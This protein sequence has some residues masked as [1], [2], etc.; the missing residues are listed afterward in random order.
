MAEIGADAL[1]ATR[2]QSHPENCRSNLRFNSF[3]A[4]SYALLY[5]AT[6][7]AACTSLKWWFSEL[8]GCAEKV[9]ASE[10]SNESSPEL[11]IHDQ[12]WR[13][14]PNCT[15]L[16][17]E[18]ILARFE[19]PNL[20]RFCLVRN[21]FTRTFSAWQSK[22]LLREPLQVGPYL[23]AGFYNIPVHSENDI[24]NAFE[25]FLEYLHAQ[26]FPQIRDAHV[27]SQFSI[28]RPDLLNFSMVAK[29]EEPEQLKEKLRGHLKDAY[30]D[31][32]S[33]SR[34]NESLIPYH[35]NFLTG[36][37]CELIQLMYSDD[38]DYFQYTRT[39]PDGKR[40]L[41]RDDLQVA[42][43]SV[44]MIRG[45]HQRIS[46]MR[47]EF[48]S[49]RERAQREIQELRDELAERQNNLS[50]LRLERQ[51][52]REEIIRAEAQ[53]ALLKELWLED[54]PLERL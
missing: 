5:I 12:L 52:L 21:P 14:A 15:G 43:Q 50:K 18:L 17:I 24:A 1:C 4:E 6:P 45:R 29:L 11:I 41:K 2:S 26:E 30:K 25:S 51:G 42:I 36:R 32:L 22:W 49:Q 31:P 38:F 40:D 33:A 28:L 27:Q 10:G 34:N 20:F 9:R 44:E 39:P 37:A 46:E 54:G 19:D 53:L 35:P 7:K 16:P 3:F 47:K 23:T 8:I 48:D 13:V